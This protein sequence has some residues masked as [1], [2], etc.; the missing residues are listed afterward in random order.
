[1]SRPIKLYLGARKDSANAAHGSTEISSLE[2]IPLLTEFIPRAKKPRL[3]CY[4][5]KNEMKNPSFVGRDDVLLQIDKVLLPSVSEGREVGLKSFA[6]CGIGGIGK[7]QIAINYG[8]SRQERFDAIFFV[9]AENQEKIAES[10]GQI[11]VKLGLVDATDA[12]DLVVCRDVALKW[13][14]H[15]LKYEGTEGDEQ[16]NEAREATWLIIFDNVDDTE[17][18]RDFWPGSSSG[19]VLITSRDPIA[20]TQMY[21]STGIDLAGLDDATGASLLRTLT[22]MGISSSQDKEISKL[23]SRRFGGM[24]IALLQIAALISRWQMTFKEFLE[25]YERE[26]QH[27][28]HSLSD[29]ALM[30]TGDSQHSLLTIWALD[31]LSPPA[32]TLLDILTFLDPENIQEFI[33]KDNLPGGLVPGFPTTEPMYL[34]ARTDLLAS[35]LIKRH[36]KEGELEMHRLVQDISSTLMDHSRKMVILCNVVSL[37]FNAWRPGESAF[38][39]DVQLWELRG[40]LSPH[41]MRL[42]TTYGISSSFLQNLE[43]KKQ[44][45][46]LL[47]VNG[48]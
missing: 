23:L 40:K 5:L 31:K 2:V 3:P 9:Q 6:L 19:A 26:T 27:T 4:A 47:Q 11:A 34:A 43:T 32:K 24:P 41:V 10:F 14:S 16:V 39:H 35:S 46:Q 20:K 45:A 44:L 22:T 21:R 38:T 15:P 42:A 33:L 29:L 1:M 17:V 13:L 8:L 18:L 36:Q 7:T 48:W 30:P 37:I 28:L 12:A 25:F